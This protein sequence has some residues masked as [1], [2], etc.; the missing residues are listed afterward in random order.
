MSG[1]LAIAFVLALAF[2]L[3]IAYVGW[4]AHLLRYYTLQAPHSEY[5]SM[6]VIGPGAGKM[7]ESL[8]YPD[9]RGWEYAGLLDTGSEPR[10]DAVAVF[11]R[12]KK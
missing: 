2:G 4:H 8:D 12:V 5:G 7:L 9:A 6:T 1:K 3:I 11:K 10:A